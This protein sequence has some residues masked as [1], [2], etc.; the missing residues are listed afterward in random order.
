MLRGVSTDTLTLGATS[1]AVPPPNGTTTKSTAGGA[2]VTDSAGADAAPAS[3]A[4]AA[5]PALV[6][7]SGPAGAVVGSISVELL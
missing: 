2:S 4:P 5:D 7:T 1:D 3:A 6:A